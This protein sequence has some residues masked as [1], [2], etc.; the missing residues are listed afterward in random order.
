MQQRNSAMNAP[1]KL[2]AGITSPA[3]I[4]TCLECSSSC[5]LFRPCHRPTPSA[6]PAPHNSQTIFTRL[7]GQAAACARMRAPHRRVDE[8]ADTGR[9]NARDER[10]DHEQQDAEV[11]G[12]PLSDGANIVRSEID[13]TIELATKPAALASAAE[14]PAALM[15]DQSHPAALKAGRSNPAALS[16]GGSNPAACADAGS[17]PSA[18]TCAAE[19]PAVLM[20]DHSH[21]A[22]LHKAAS[23]PA[24]LR[25]GASSDLVH[26]LQVCPG[27]RAPRSLQTHSGP[28]R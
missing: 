14:N 28:H 15:V 4:T 1:C 12:E 16:D 17:Q 18:L 25:D 10:L 11:N 8:V 26:Q 13:K 24:A 27:L 21:P 9:K 3:I 2:Y 20:V 6:A 23:K 5:R 22:A 19:N 7:L